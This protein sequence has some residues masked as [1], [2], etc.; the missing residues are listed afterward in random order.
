M[1]WIGDG[2]LSTCKG[3]IVSGQD[4]PDGALT[5]ERVSHLVKAGLIESDKKAEKADKKAGGK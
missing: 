3:D 1:K 5:D 2:V 4:I